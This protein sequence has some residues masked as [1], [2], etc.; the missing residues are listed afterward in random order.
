M[1]CWWICAPGGQ[2]GTWNLRGGV[3]CYD[4]P[5]T[6]SLHWGLLSGLKDK[7]CFEFFCRLK[8]RLWGWKTVKRKEFYRESMPYGGLLPSQD[9]HLSL[10][11]CNCHMAWLMSYSFSL[12]MN[13]PG[14]EE[15]LQL[16]FL[17]GFAWEFKEVRL[18]WLWGYVVHV[19]CNKFGSWCYTG[20]L[21]IASGCFSRISSW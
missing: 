4:R 11:P 7:Q 12:S 9:F 17:T 13:K 3:L 15:E 1:E 6:E 18:P 5:V 8:R 10:M 16:I 2:E 14:I 20:N 21:C 19:W